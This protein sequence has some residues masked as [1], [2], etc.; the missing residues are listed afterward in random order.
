MSLNFTKSFFF[1]PKLLKKVLFLSL[2]LSLNYWKNSLQSLGM[3]KFLKFRN[4]KQ[5]FVKV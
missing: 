3:K 5:T 4:E 1:I 2:F